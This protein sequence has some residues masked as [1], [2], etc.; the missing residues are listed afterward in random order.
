MPTQ[1]P[2]IYRSS[3]GTPGTTSSIV[4]VEPAGLFDLARFLD[5]DVDWGPLH[6]G[7]HI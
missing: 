6:G 1:A 4:G 2:P 5:I 3:A 7:L